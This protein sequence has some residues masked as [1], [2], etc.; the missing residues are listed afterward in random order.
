MLRQPFWIGTVK[1]SHGRSVGN[2]NIHHTGLRYHVPVFPDRG[3]AWHIECP[4]I[5]P[6]GH[7]TAIEVNPVNINAGVFQIYYLAIIQRVLHVWLSK[8]PVMVTGD[9]H[10]IFYSALVKQF[11]EPV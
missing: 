4:I 2:K 7:W 9:C 3:T 5:K 6:W 11:V 1:D 10:H 8:G